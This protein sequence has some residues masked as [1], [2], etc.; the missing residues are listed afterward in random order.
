M[1]YPLILG[2]KKKRDCFTPINEIFTI[3]FAG[4][5]ISK[6]VKR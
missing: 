5:K 4:H 3:F 6:A 1:F 2:A